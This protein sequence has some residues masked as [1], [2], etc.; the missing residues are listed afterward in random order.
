MADVEDVFELPPMPA[1]MLLHT[2][3]APKSGTYFQQCWCILEGPLDHARFEAAWRQVIRRHQ[4]LRSE[5]HW[6]DLDRPVQ[7]IYD[8]AEPEWHLADWSQLGGEEQETAFTSWL[9]ADRGRG[10]RLDKAPL[11]RF[12]LI[13]LAEGRHRFVWSFHHLLMD[14]WCGSLL[15]GEMLQLYAGA[16]APPVP[17]P[18]RRYVEWREAQDDAAARTYWSEALAGMAGSTPLGIDRAIGDGAAGAVVEIR[19]TLDPEIAA[20]LS[21]MARRQRLTFATI[22]QGAWALLLDRYSGQDDIVFGTVLSG[23]PPE[24]A[25]VEQMV[26]L[27][28]N[29][30]PV[31]VSTDARQTL[32]SWLQA[33]QAEHRHREK[34]GHA[35][36][37]DIQRW[38]GS[39]K[40]LFDSVLIVENFPLTIEGAVAAEGSDLTLSDAGSYERTH[41]PLVLRVFPGAQTVMALTVDPGRILPSDAAR[42]LKHFSNLLSAFVAGPDAR[43]GE[44]D[45]LDP[46]ER[47][48]LLDM[49]RGPQSAPAAPIHLQVLQRIDDVPEATAIIHVG[50]T[51]D[52]AITYRD[53]AGRI[54]V[55]AGALHQSG[56]GRGSVVAV[57][58]E[59]GPDLVPAMLAVMASGATYLPVDPGYPPERI[60]Y[61]LRDSGTALILSDRTEPRALDLPQEI[62][63][64]SVDQLDVNASDIVPASIL[65]DD[66]AYILYTSGSTGNP[67]GVPIT[68]GALSNFMQ[69]M[70]ASPGIGAQDRLLALTTIGFDISGLELFCPLTRG[71]TVVLADTAITRDGAKLV[72]LMKRLQ[73]SVMQATPAGW[74]MLV[75]AGWT[76]D[77]GLKMLCGGEALDASLAR[78]L[79]GLGGELWNLYGPTE[80]TIWSAAARVESNLPDDGGVPVAG[81][82]DHTQL[83]VLDDSG[84]LVPVGIAGELHIGGAGLSPGYWRRPD[85]AADRFIPN[86]FRTDAGDSLHLYRT[87]D[88]VRWRADG[89]LEFLGR[90]DNQIKLRG[91]RI[92]P[93]E[94]ESRLAAHPDVAEAAVLLEQAPVGARLVAYLRWRGGVPDD[95][96]PMLRAHLAETLPPYMLPSAYVSLPLFPMTPN[97]KVDRRA[98]AASGGKVA[99]RSVVRPAVSGEPAATLASIWREMLQVDGVLPADN[100]FDLGGHSLLVT[101]MQSVVRERLAVTLDITDFFRFPTLETLAAHVAAL[102]D[103]PVASGQPDGRTQL[104]SAGRDRLS[105]RRSRTARA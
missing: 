43:L 81:P 22:L 50:A 103:P 7:V 29:T 99:T 48:A 71:G 1:G 38:G 85:L 55:L 45:L 34:F 36:L 58:M 96:A 4:V 60:A 101:R 79:Q 90:I 37:S 72:D 62:A 70:A 76:G 68:H 54:S 11:L 25:G 13:R 80:T 102:R 2:L 92:E 65:P 78:R 18:Y 97:G 52:T 30:V 84:D 75:E 6:E 31:R 86:A 74:R 57:C 14:G 24:L 89:A 26:G 49:G 88:R 27:F 77:L 3:M 19:E 20:R 64:L 100:F 51:G 9:E 91:F 104:R 69:A 47:R 8:D 53:M 21:A 61:M 46:Q 42:L 44:I 98:L 23:R 83:Y 5:C 87:G 15:V 32:S 105:Q 10:F 35:A 73:P 28:L 95:P 56:I 16:A 82:I 94:I 41:Y 33:L 66:L 12:A 17:P 67:K 63:L 40:S 93:G 59:R 39:G